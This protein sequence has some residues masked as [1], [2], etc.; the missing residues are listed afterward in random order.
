MSVSMSC[1]WEAD[2]GAW[3][4]R[5]SDVVWGE[6]GWGEIVWR[7]SG[8]LYTSERRRVCEIRPV[9]LWIACMRAKEDLE[10]SGGVVPARSGQT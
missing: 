7:M 2:V 4:D 6:K 8:C 10:D 3:C 5:D 9:R 1:D